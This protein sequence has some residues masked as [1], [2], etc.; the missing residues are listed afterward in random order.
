MARK[1]ERSRW[2][3]MYFPEEGLKEWMMKAAR[4]AGT[5]AGHFV[6][7]LLDARRQWEADPTLPCPT[8]GR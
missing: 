7:T 1:K 5:S 2:F 4:R 3:T 6:R 8:C